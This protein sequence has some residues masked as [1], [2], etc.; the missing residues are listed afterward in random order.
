M[1]QRAVPSRFPTIAQQRSYAQLDSGF[2][3]LSYELVNRMEAHQRM[4]GRHPFNDRRLIEFALA[5]PEDQRWRGDQT[6]YVLRQAM[7]RQLPNSILQGRSKAD[8]TFLFTECLARERA[9]PVFRTLRLAKEGYVDAHEV[10]AMY[11]RCCNGKINE[12]VPLWMV[13]ALELWRDRA[14]S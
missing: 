11:A 3:A 14:F 4:E 9:G 1:M 5:L 6:K 12:A 10:Q 2:A 13:L 8:Y 7:R